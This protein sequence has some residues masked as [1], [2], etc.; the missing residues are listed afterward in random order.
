MFPEGGKMTRIWQT[1][2]SQCLAKGWSSDHL[3]R[4]RSVTIYVADCFV[5]HGL[6]RRVV[7]RIGD[8]PVTETGRGF[9][10]IKLV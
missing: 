7:E 8:C 5:T 2:R 4:G 1:D 9:Q 6:K 3:E 10:T